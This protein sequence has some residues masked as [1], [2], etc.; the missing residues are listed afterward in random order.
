[1]NVANGPAVIPER[2]PVQ[3]IFERIRKV[4]LDGKAASIYIP[5]IT[6]DEKNKKKFEGASRATPAFSATMSFA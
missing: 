3:P 2:F 4:G 5:F 6:Y 1:M